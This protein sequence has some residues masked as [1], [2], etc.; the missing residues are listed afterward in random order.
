MRH[1]QAFLAG[2]VLLPVVFFLMAG[3]GPARGDD[4]P[5]VNDVELQPFA[6]QVKR[7]IEALETLGQ[8]LAASEKTENR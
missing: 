8:P 4:L 7:V 5:M 6:A 2:F 1:F 3:P